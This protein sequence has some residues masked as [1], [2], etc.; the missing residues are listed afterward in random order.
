MRFKQHWIGYVNIDYICTRKDK[1]L[2]DATLDL[3]IKFTTSQ[4]CISFKQLS[5][6]SW[7]VIFKAEIN[8][9][10][11]LINNVLWQYWMSSPKIDMH[12]KNNTIDGLLV[13]VHCSNYY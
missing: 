4:Q 11:Q 8:V 6:I 10:K 12:H 1:E 3:D 5:E 7:H 13:L 2:K 9:T